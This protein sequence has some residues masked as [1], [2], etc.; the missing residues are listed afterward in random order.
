MKAD[1]M[2]DTYGA[3]SIIAIVLG[4]L[5]TFISIIMMLAYIALHSLG[6]ILCFF[7]FVLSVLSVIW[8]INKH[9][10]LSR[11]ISYSNLI[12]SKK[13]ET[14]SQLAAAAGRPVN[15][16]HQELMRMI[17]AK[18][19]YGIY[20]NQYNGKIVFRSRPTPPPVRRSVMHQPPI[21]TQFAVVKCQNCGGS[22]KLLRG[23]DGRCDYCDSAI[24]G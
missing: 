3:V 4:V 8:G 6:A 12:M 21:R 14:V 15:T 2:I 9:S 23:S 17:D 19:L 22:T 10:F 1:S 24:H 16:V 5:A 18:Y 11:C 7:I 13:A 20:I